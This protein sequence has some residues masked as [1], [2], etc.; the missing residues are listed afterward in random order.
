MAKNYS[1]L[2]FAYH[3]P[4]HHLKKGSTQVK[5]AYFQMP[6]RPLDPEEFEK[7]KQRARTA[8]TAEHENQLRSVTTY[9]AE[10]RKKQLDEPTQSRVRP[11]SPT[12]LHRPHPPEIFLMTRLHRIPGHD[13]TSKNTTNPPLRDKLEKNPRRSP[14]WYKPNAL[15]QSTMNTDRIRELLQAV[16][17]DSNVA[18]AAEAWMKLT[19][20][21]DRQAV[22]SMIDCII[23]TSVDITKKD[24]ERQ[25]Y[26]NQ[27]LSR[28]VKPQYV[29]PISHWLLKAGREES[30]AVER[31]LRTL[32]SN[33]GYVQIKGPCFQL[34]KSACAGTPKPYVY[35]YQ[36]HPE[37]VTQ[38][39][40][41]QYRQSKT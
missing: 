22:K 38:P 37:W 18:R 40:H 32:S 1:P 25:S 24:V 13:S 7:I 16:L 9:S 29:T 30:M 14:G 39:W 6:F 23:S 19:G 20:E 35:D 3:T 21:K 34:T 15:S 4:I 11:N 31:L 5:T 33:P 26:I 8:W 41:I 12:R 28:Y 36:I 10:H 27:A 17:N 2:A